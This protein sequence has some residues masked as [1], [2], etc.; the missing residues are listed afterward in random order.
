MRIQHLCQAMAEIAPLRLAEDWDNVGLLLGA[1]AAPVAR[2]MTCLTVTSAVVAEAEAENVDLLIAH[3]P[4]P[5]QPMRKITTD[6]AA[7]NLLWRLCL[8]GTSLYSAHT[9][10]DSAVDG[11]NDQWCEALDLR[12]RG[13]LVAKTESAER[14]EVG[15]RSGENGRAFDKGLVGAGRYGDLPEP[16]PAREILM[17]AAKFSG[18]TRPRMVGDDQRPVQRIG[19]A[20]GSGGSFLGAARRVG[21]DLLLTGEATFHNS[22]EAENTGIFLAMLGHYASERFAMESLAQRLQTS[23]DLL[24]IH[25]K[26][27]STDDFRVWASHRECDVIAVDRN[28]PNP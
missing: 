8:S 15:D 2:V 28:S 7:G 26:S 6:S 21:C 1:R 25:A 13:A 12:G 23:P 3:H 27:A 11:I 4:L 24:K 20:C 9:A 18:A 10:Y 14:S 22:L 19:V 17:A 16:R 5:F